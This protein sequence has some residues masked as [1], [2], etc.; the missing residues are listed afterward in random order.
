[1]SDSPDVD[2]LR[3][4]LRDRGIDLGALETEPDGTIIA[5]PTGL[6]SDDDADAAAALPSLTTGPTPHIT[7]GEAI[8]RGGMG[9]V[10]VG[11]QLPLRRR[12]AVKRSHPTG[13][14]DRRA[15]RSLLREA[16]ALGALEHPNVVPVYALG[17]GDDHRAML[18]MKKVEGTAWSEFIEGALPV[19]EG[20]DALEWHL[21]VLMAV[22]NAIH[23]AHS[24]GILHRDIKPENVMIGDFGEAYLVDWGMVVSVA[25]DDPLGLPRAADVHAPCGTP[26]YMAPEMVA[27]DGDRLGPRTD[28]YLLGGCLHAILTG[29]P[30]HAGHEAI[31]VM[32]S[33]F[34]S[35]PHDYGAYDDVPA[36]LAAIANRATAADPADRPESAEAFRAELADYLRYRHSAT[37]TAE[38]DA[39]AAGLAALLGEPVGEREAGAI[40]AHFS[41]ARFGYEQALREWPENAAARDGLQGSL[42]AM[43]RHELDRGEDEAA[44]VFLAELPRP[45]Q[46]L[47]QRIARS[48]IRRSS[49]R[50]A[51]AE[52]ARFRHDVDPGVGQ[53]QRRL[54]AMVIGIGFGFGQVVIG[55]LARAE[56]YVV[57]HGSSMVLVLVYGACIA[58]YMARSRDVLRESEINR[59]FVGVLWTVFVGG[60]LGWSVAWLLE[61]TQAQGIAIVLVAFAVGSLNVGVALG[62]RLLWSGVPVGAGAIGAALS[63]A[64]AYEIM[65]AAI[66]GSL[67]SLAWLWRDPAGEDATE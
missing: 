51:V 30:R 61:L 59:R 52:L 26:A 12:V 21:G 39:R 46:E 49:E 57:E 17:Q 35:P 18:V 48:R 23:Y 67:C 64:W 22:C 5:S 25:D 1:M 15:E 31:Q 8:G 66:A 9:A 54:I 13:R 29:R 3:A 45:S 6:G 34:L 32:A 4:R 50:L 24:K 58:A 11:H 55:A 7:L 42:E 44:A 33:A 14:D 28:V 65:G 2:R 10:F 43:V 53:A 36:S 20:H 56:V 60:M 40:H 63:P 19:P 38:A 27:G 47:E 16:F 62:R 37:L 41:A